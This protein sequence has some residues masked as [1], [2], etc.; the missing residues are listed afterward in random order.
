ME[1]QSNEIVYVLT[2]PAMIGLVKIGRTTQKDIGDRMRQLYT[3]GVP[4]P[5]ECEYACRVD[6]CSKVEKAFHLAFGNTRINSSREFFEIEPERVIA[7]LK[8]LAV[9][10]VTPQVEGYLAENVS[11]EEKVSAKK[12]KANRR[13][14][15][16]FIEMGIPIGSTLE[17]KDG[18][19]SVQIS[20]QKKVIYN[21]NTCSLTAATQEIMDLDYAV[22]PAT[23]WSFEGKTLKEIY[24]ETYAV[25][26][27][28]V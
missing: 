14:P 23:H 2:N 12:M 26:F 8:L 3:T 13:P 18:S 9:A 17:Y 19:V 22:Q 24:D 7:I 1:E 20:E 5:F 11:L 16:N 10:D 25:E 15:M 27:S 28:E 21:G 4:L 6:D